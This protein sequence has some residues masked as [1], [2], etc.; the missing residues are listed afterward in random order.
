M[1][2]VAEHHG[3]ISEFV[4]TGQKLGL[5]QSPPDPSKSCNDY[6]PNE[7]N[8]SNNRVR[9]GMKQ[10]CHGLQVNFGPIRLVQTSLN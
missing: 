5:L 1:V 4:N 10:L 3:L 9:A 6:Y 7:G 8:H 2:L